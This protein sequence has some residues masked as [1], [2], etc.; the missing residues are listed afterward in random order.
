MVRIDQE[1]GAVAAVA[2]FELGCALF[3]ESTAVDPAGQMLWTWLSH[4]SGA[5]AFV[6][7][8]DLQAGSQVKNASVLSGLRLPWSPMVWVPEG[9]GNSAV[10]G[11]VAVDS[12]NWLSLLAGEKNETRKVSSGELKGIAANNGIAV[13]AKTGLV[14]ASLVNF[15]KQ[16]ITTIDLNAGGKMA[17]SP[18]KWTVN[19]CNFDDDG[20]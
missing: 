15:D 17:S 4:S 3:L 16:L 8:F 5:G 13:S 14:F 6:A 7:V 11:L 18:L 12:L 10:S 2:D 19:Y 20:L 1:S 9:G